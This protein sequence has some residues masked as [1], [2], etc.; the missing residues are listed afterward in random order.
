MSWTKWHEDEKVNTALVRL[1]DELCTWERDTGRGSALILILEV[2]DGK[3]LWAMDGKP[4]SHH[5]SL[6]NF[7]KTEYKRLRNISIASD[8]KRKKNLCSTCR[9]AEFDEED[10]PYCIVAEPV[11]CTENVESCESYD[12]ISSIIKHRKRST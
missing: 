11:E 6:E 7:I 5:S 10:R 1:L 4:V 2:E 9:H 8:T 3:V 12:P